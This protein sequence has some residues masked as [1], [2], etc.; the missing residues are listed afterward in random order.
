[1]ATK[2]TKSKN[3]GTSLALFKAW[4]TGIEEMQGE[5]WS[6]NLEQWKRIKS[7]LMDIEDTPS[8]PAYAEPPRLQQ[9]WIPPQQFTPPTSSAFDVAPRMPIQHMESTKTP[10]IDSSAGY[11]SSLV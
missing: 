7:K 11:Q 8:V 2:G 9:P 4:L 6:P 10:D 5:D 3:T 1:M